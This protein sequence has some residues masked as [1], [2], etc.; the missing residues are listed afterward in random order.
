MQ[1]ILAGNRQALK[2]IFNHKKAQIHRQ[3]NR[4]INKSSTNSIEFV[5]L[6]INICS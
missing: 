2:L 5:E 6:K 4:L 3:I 1:T